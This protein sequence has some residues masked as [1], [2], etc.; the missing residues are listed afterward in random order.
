MAIAICLST[1]FSEEHAR[2]TDQ[3]ILC[4]RNGRKKLFYAKIL[5]G[6]TFG[7]SVA[8]ILFLL[9]MISTVWVYGG[10]GFDTAV[11]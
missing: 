8:I 3:L 2:K 6:V 4:S 1:V 10:R 7:V 11:G 9:A 5:A